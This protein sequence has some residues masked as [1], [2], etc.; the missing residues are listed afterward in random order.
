[1]TVRTSSRKRTDVTRVRRAFQLENGAVKASI[2]M[3]SCGKVA[4]LVKGNY[5][6]PPKDDPHKH[7][8]SPLARVF[9]LQDGV[10][11]GISDALSMSF[12]GYPKLREVVLGV[13][14][15]HL[16]EN[17][18][19]FSTN[20]ET[21]KPYT[22]ESLE[23]TNLNGKV[24]A[25]G[26]STIT[27]GLNGTSDQNQDFIADVKEAVMLRFRQQ[28]PVTKKWSYPWLDTLKFHGV[29]EKMIRPGPSNGKYRLPP[30]AKPERWDDLPF[31]NKR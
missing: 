16:S 7:G 12:A 31:S 5:C 3:K 25:K 26:K 22:E 6:P 2:L 28:D 30:S 9:V 24:C 8:T 19:K 4:T 13:M 11:G 14:E 17:R 27:V 18:M 20:R 10:L 15:K 29:D 23:Y 21:G 1:M